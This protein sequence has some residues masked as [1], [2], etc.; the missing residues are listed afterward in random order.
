MS[1]IKDP[2]ITRGNADLLGILSALIISSNVFG[3]YENNID[4]FL[5]LR[6]DIKVY[7]NS[8]D[9]YLFRVNK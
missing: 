9:D 3:H 2:S 7:L 4:E 1:G 8:V 5:S 6:F